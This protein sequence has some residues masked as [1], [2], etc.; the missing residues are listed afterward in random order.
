MAAVAW[1]PEGMTWT[2]LVGRVWRAMNEDDVFG[3]A[4]KLAYYFA[5]SAVPLL[6]CLVTA[7]GLFTRNEELRGRLLSYLSTFAPASASALIYTVVEEIGQQS[8]RAKLS[9]GIAA[10][11]WAAS[12]GTAAVIEALNVAYDARETRPWWKTRL[13]AVALTLGLSSSVI[14]G[15]GLLLYGSGLAEFISRVRGLGGAFVLVWSLLQWPF[16]AFSML[17]AFMVLYSLGPDVQFQDLRWVWPGAVVGVILWFAVSFG[18]RVYFLFF[19]SYSVTYGSLGAVVV[20]MLWFW[21]TG[22]AILVGGEYNAV[23]AQEARDKGPKGQR[24]KGSDEASRAV[25]R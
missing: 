15:L 11:L 21:F 13:L 12:S 24:V 9:L 10:T 18:L 8:G 20:L 6:I 14:V 7:L 19:D 3:Q 23:L 22:M 17:G 25:G 1:K 4:A 5:L 16:I 2:N